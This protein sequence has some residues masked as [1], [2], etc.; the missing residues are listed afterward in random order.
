GLDPRVAEPQGRGPPA[1]LGEGGP[2]DP[3]KGWT[4]K[5]AALT[6]TFSIEQGGV[7]CTSLRLQLVEVDQPAPAAQVI[8]AVDDGFDAQRPAVFEVL[9]DHRVSVEGVDADLGAV[10]GDLGLELASCFGAAVL[11][12]F[13]DQFDE[14]RAAD[15]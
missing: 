1:I 12:A 6:D 13:D 11:A 4:R 7:D 14:F 3:L 15:V 8:G 5:D 2:R 9:L 10:G